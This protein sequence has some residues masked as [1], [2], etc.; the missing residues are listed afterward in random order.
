MKGRACV[1]AWRVGKA[2]G[3]VLVGGGDD[4]DCEDEDVEVEVGKKSLMRVG[5]VLFG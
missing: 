5:V 2:V 3:F 1:D 4:D